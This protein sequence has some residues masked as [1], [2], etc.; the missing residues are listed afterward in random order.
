MVLLVNKIFL[1]LIGI[2]IIFFSMIIIFGSDLLSPDFQDTNERYFDGYNGYNYLL[3]YNIHLEDKDIILNAFNNSENITI[4]NTSK[5]TRAFNIDLKYNM[6]DISREELNGFSTSLWLNI[7]SHSTFH[8]LFF[9]PNP[10]FGL[11]E[12]IG[13]SD[14]IWDEVNSQMELDREIVDKYTI[15]LIL[16]IE[17]I[18]DLELESKYIST[19]N[20]PFP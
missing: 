18:L 14:E 19:E 3:G 6:S 11:D 7:D 15:S 17:E 9:T 10:I 13:K 8:I 5:R 16:H 2:T 20:L 12:P 4:I 1:G